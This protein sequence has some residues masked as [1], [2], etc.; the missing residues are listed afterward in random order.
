MPSWFGFKSSSTEQN[1]PSQPEQPSSFPADDALSPQS[2]STSPQGITVSD[3][4]A[5]MNTGTTDFG[6]IKE[7][8]APSPQDEVELLYLSD[9]PLGLPT[10]APPTGTFGPLPMRT[11]YDKLLYGTGTAYLAGLVFGGG[12]GALRGLRTAQVPTMKVR[13][14]NLLNQ[15]TRYGPWAANS[16]SVLTMGW[17]L[18]DNTL[19][20][21]RG[22][23]DYYNHIGAAF[24][25]GLIFKCTAGLRPAVLTGSICASVVGGYGVWETI[26]G[27]AV[28]LPSLN[29]G[30]AAS[31]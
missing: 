30:F 11:N 25:S 21:A 3:M 20:L 27:G 8:I 18:L 23:S 24:T 31:T 17:A 19:E 28:E 13:I 22:T 1:A 15:S 6:S 16:L 4:L 12:Y 5:G 9:N 7:K 29:K 10:T 14:N 2:H 26:T